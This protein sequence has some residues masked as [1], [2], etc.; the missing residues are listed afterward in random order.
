VLRVVI[1]LGFDRGGRLES[2]E[3]FDLETGV[4]R[5]CISSA[6]YFKSGFVSREEPLEMRKKHRYTY[7]NRIILFDSDLEE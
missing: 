7:D 4:D 2:F 6:I 3:D 5:D 1:R